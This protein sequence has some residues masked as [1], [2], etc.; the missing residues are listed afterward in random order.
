MSLKYRF[1]KSDRA[2]PAG[3]VK[4]HRNG[5]GHSALANQIPQVFAGGV[6]DAI[7]K[8]QLHLGGAHALELKGQPA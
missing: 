1:N 6:F 4:R 8:R 2:L 5:A 7:D 3:G